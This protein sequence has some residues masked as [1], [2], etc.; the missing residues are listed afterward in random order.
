M[1]EPL[2]ET[3]EALA[4]LISL[5]GPEVDEVIFDLGR[6]AEQIVPTSSASAWPCSARV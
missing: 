3:R 1:L 6:A 2:P 4:E 5:D